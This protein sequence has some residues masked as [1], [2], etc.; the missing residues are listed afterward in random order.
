MDKEWMSKDR[1]S[2]EFDIGVESFLQIAL[3]NAIHSDAIPCPCARCCN[4]W[5]KNFETIRAHLYCNGMDLTYHTWIWHG[6]RSTKG[7]SMNDNDRVGQDEHKSFSE[8]PIDMVHCVYESYAENPRQFNK[9]LEDA[10]KPLYPGCAKFTKLSAVV[11]LFNL[12]A[13]YSWRDKSFTDLLILFGEMLPDHNELLSSLYDA[14]KSLRALG[15]DYVKI[16]ACPNDCI[17]YRKEYEDFANLPYLRDVKVEVGQ[18]IKGKGRNSCKGLVS[19][20]D[21]D[22]YISPLIDDLNCL[23]DKGVEAYDAYREESFSLR[24]VLLWTINDFPVYENMFGCVVKGYHACTI[25][26]EETYST[27]FKHCRK[28][29]YTG[30]RRFLPLSHPYR[31]QKKAFNGKQEF[32][33]EPKPLSGN[34]ILERVQ[35]IIYHCGKFSGKLQSKNDDEITCWKKKSI[36]FELEYWKDL[37]VR[38]VLDV[39]HIEKNVCESLIGTLLDVPGKTK[40]GIAARL[41]LL[42][43]NLRTELAPRIEE[44]KTFLPAAYY[45]LSKDEKRSICNSLS[46]VKVPVG[47]SSNVRNLVSMKDLKL[48]GLKS[49]DYHTL[50]Q[51]LLPVAILDVL[52]KHVRDTITRLCFFFNVLYSEVIDVLKLDDLQKR[53][54]VDI[55]LLEKYFPP[56][57]FDIM[58]HLTVHL[59]RDVKLCGPVWYRHMYPFERFMKILKDY[60]RNRNRPEGWCIAECYIA[61]EAVEFCSDYLSNV[62]TIGIPSRHR[63]V[64]LTKPLSGAVAHLVDH[65]THQISE[66]LMWLAHGPCNKV[67]KYSSYLIDGVTYATKERDDIRV[68]KKSGVSLVAK[69]M[70]VASEKDKNPIVSDM[71]FYGVIEEI[72][73]LD[74][75]NFQIPM[76]KCNWVENNNDIKVDDLCFT[77]VN[78]RRIGFKSESF[79]LGSQAK[80]VFY[81]EDPED[82]EWSIVL[83]TPT[84]ESFEHVDGD[85]LEDTLID[86]Q[87]FTRGLPSMGVDGAYDNE[88]SWLREDCDGNWVDNV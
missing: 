30:H 73:E 20:N 8:E 4:L 37:H 63:E 53:D 74:Y 3:K 33:L 6:E 54:C 14:K 49:H 32:N 76:F 38:H 50:M 22:V 31:R 41:D 9:I 24:A 82:P 44:K 88:P 25:C 85:E 29:S 62:H 12:K 59:V 34:E 67:L 60:V 17:L 55:V 7:N 58:I 86:Y 78:L 79:I 71:V 87:S 84:R 47:Y 81:I 28:M 23:W 21:I 39:M 68:T 51:Q 10:D 72:W 52:P 46:G 77:L 36:F 5:K 56:S 48:V 45:T 13:K 16:H 15:I 61:E 27:R 69:I 42:E 70:Q 57:F 83:A 1:L 26:A 40:D 66:I 35:R 43:M 2:Y 75:H 80:Q 11:K 18:Q 65:S 64:E 19:G